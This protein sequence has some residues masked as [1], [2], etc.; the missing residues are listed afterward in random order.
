MVVF[1]YRWRDLTIQ[2]TVNGSIVTAEADS[3][4][5]ILCI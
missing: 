2:Q 4:D 5:S 3:K 1:I